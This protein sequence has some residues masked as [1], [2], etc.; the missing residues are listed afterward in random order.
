MYKLS[1]VQ[2]SGEQ[3]YKVISRGAYWNVLLC[4]S[5]AFKVFYECISLTDLD[6]GHN[7]VV[8]ALDELHLL[9]GKTKRFDSFS[10]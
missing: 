5:C 1:Y 9:I 4:G 3:N 6:L 8:E 7:Y 2:S 10:S